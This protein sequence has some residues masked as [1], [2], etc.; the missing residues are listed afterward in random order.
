MENTTFKNFTDYDFIRLFI[1][2]IKLNK[3][4]FMDKDN[5][6]YDLYQYSINIG[7]K[8]LFEEIPIKILAL[9]NYLD[10]KQ[11]INLAIAFGFISNTEDSKI[12]LTQKEAKKII[13][14][15]DKVYKKQ[16]SDLVIDYIEYKHRN[17][18]VKTLQ[19]NKK[20]Y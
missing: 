19:N 16:M 11:A 9:E 2:Y 4:S 7:Y 10:I 15:Y 3:E 1:S 14:G 5:L 17:I 6:K 13:A 20:N 18:K 8:D 12:L